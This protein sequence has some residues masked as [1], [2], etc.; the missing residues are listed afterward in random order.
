VTGFGAFLLDCIERA[1]EGASPELLAELRV[2]RAVMDQH[3]GTCDGAE[4]VTCHVP[5][6]CPT[7]R[8]HAMPYEDEPGF[9]SDWLV[10]RP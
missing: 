2:K 3:Q 8:L 4:C 5:V 9:D 6:P 7:L 1:E 10:P